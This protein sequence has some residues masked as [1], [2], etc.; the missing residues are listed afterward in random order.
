[1]TNTTLLIL[2][3]TGDL[4]KRLLLPGIGSLIAGGDQGDLDLLDG[5]TLVGSARSGMSEDDWRGLVRTAFEGVEASGDLAD[6]IV[7]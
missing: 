1:M 4:T 7:E 6:A 2:G 5:L 3:A